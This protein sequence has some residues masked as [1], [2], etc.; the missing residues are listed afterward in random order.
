MPKL[1]LS[2]SL[3][4]LALAT[5]ERSKG[6]EAKTGASEALLPKA[7]EKRIEEGFGVLNRLYWSPTLSI[8][9]DRTGDDLRAHFEGRRNPPWWSSA[10]AIETMIDFMDV[11]KRK[12]FDEA[13]ALL[14]DL[15]RIP[16]GTRERLVTELKKRGQWNDKD[17]ERFQ[18][19]LAKRKAEG[20]VPVGKLYSEFRNEYL[21]DSGWWG[22]AWLKMYDRTHNE[23]YLATAKA[24]HEHVAKT[25][26]PEKG[27]GVMWCLDEDKLKANSIT[28]S[29]FLILSARLYERTKDVEYLDWAQKTLAWF[30]DQKL[31]DGTAVVD[32]PGHTGDYWTYNQG[33]YVGALTALFRATGDNAYLDEAAKAAETIVE[34]SGDVLPDGVA[35]EKLGTSG[36][37]TG[38]FKGIM[39]R[40]FGQLRDELERQK[41]NPGVSAKLDQVIRAS[42][43]SMLKESVSPE[44]EFTV[45]WEPGAKDQT[46]N[47][48]THTAG[49]AALVAALRRSDF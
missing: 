9:L 13:I 26:N 46:H 23:R 18:R 6:Q 27:G 25:W 11:A 14:Y 2:A 31:Y 24:I 19:W 40:Y 16:G 49:L 36:W 47:F 32:C 48:N 3:L 39:I 28:N 45:S 4:L 41:S 17:E 15:H 33:A 21:D 7:V 34:R 44:G 30:R 20:G 29:L 1:F 8:W 22:I 38:L 42:V 5:V 12:D 43:S 10:N 37:D 35:V